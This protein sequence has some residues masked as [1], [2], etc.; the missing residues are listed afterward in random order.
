[1]I[2]LLH[3]L[4]AWILSYFIF[5][6]IVD[7]NDLDSGLYSSITILFV[8]VYFTY[9]STNKYKYKYN[10]NYNKNEYMTNISSQTDNRNIREEP[11]LNINASVKCNQKQNVINQ[12]VLTRSDVDYDFNN[13]QEPIHNTYFKMNNGQELYG[14]PTFMNNLLPNDTNG[15]I[16][17]IYSR[18]SCSSN[19]LLNKINNLHENNL[20]KENLYNMIK[21][22]F[23]ESINKVKY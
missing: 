7:L 9:F 12:D 16:N 5:K 8:L 23:G 17:S 10:Y 14:E 11:K 2:I 21:N 19:E 13:Y 6:H 15:I 4:V 3:Y 20:D 18:P 22:D 1:M